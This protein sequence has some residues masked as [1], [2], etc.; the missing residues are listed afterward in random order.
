MKNGGTGFGVPRGSNSSSSYVFKNGNVEY[1]VYSS[2]PG[3]GFKNMNSFFDHSED[4]DGEDM[5][6]QQMFGNFTRN[7]N[8]KN[9]PHDNNSNNGTFDN[10]YNNCRF[11][12]N[13]FHQRENIRRYQS[14]VRQCVQFCNMLP[15]IFLFVLLIFPYINILF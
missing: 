13:A 9:R 15:I 1:K 5:F 2:F 3:N 7:I 4:D 10:D 8:N 14:F 12:S 11:D 6:R